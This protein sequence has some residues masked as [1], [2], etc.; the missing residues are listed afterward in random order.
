MVC[1]AVANA[2]GAV[3]RLRQS[4]FAKKLR[5]DKEGFGA[6]AFAH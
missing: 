4:A 6:A 3:A 5:R 1:R 2:L